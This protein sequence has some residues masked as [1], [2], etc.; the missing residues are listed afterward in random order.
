MS[1]CNPPGH[2]LDNRVADTIEACGGKKIG[3]RTAKAAAHHY[4]DLYTLAEVRYS[5]DLIFDGRE[6]SL[7][8]RAVN[9]GEVTVVSEKHN[10]GYWLPSEEDAATAVGCFLDIKWILTRGD[11]TFIERVEESRGG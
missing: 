11:D 5:S 8:F 9:D 2:T 3:Y 1:K 7:L 6:V 4:G 10:N